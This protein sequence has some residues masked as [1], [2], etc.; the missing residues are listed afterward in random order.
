MR[1]SIVFLF[2]LIALSESCPLVWA[3]S[4]SNLELTIQTNQISV[5]VRDIFAVTTT[6][7]NVSKSV[8]TLHIY[9]C[10]NDVFWTTDNPKVGIVGPS[11]EK[12]VIREIKL[13]PNE[14]RKN[15]LALA[16]DLAPDNSSIEVPSSISLRL[17]FTNNGDNPEH[18]TIAEPIWS[19]SITLKIVK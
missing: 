18:G 14:S 13:K 11:C 7:Q 4:A 17:G 16:I 2:M 1:K 10:S 6:I 3:E 9:T 15:R 12:N 5:K 19:N 8:Q